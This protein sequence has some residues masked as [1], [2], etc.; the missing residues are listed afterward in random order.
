MSLTPL[1]RAYRRGLAAA[2][3]AEPEQREA[4][5]AW[6]LPAGERSGRAHLRLQGG[7]RARAAGSAS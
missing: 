3:R 4:E 6:P 1:W 2:G 5:A 7:A